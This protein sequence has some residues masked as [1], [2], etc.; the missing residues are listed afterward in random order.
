MTQPSETILVENYGAIRILKLNRP[1]VRNA[2]SHGLQASLQKHLDNA[3][4]DTSVRAVIL[5]GSGKAFCAGLDLDELKAIST[6]RTEEN[7]KDSEHFAKLLETIYTFEKPVIAAL[8]GHAVAGGAGIAS[9]CDLVV[10]SNEAKLGYTESKIGFVAALVG[11]YLVRQIGEKHAR[12]LLLS[13][14]LITADEAMQMGLVNHVVEADQVLA[15]ALT[16]AEEMV[17]NSPSS[18]AMTKKLLAA[19][20]S[21]GLHEGIRYA[22]ELNAL[23]RTTNDLKEGVSSFLEKRKP[24][25]Q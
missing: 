25:W 17:Q 22:I 10:M 9:V 14:R 19:V 7:R 11:I 6:R 16:L 18:L 1:E 23:A 15:K 24:V 12:D 13:A 20:P 3:Q 5:T 8:N 4:E 21:M 2:L